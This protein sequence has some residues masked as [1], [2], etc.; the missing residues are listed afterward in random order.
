[1]PGVGYLTQNAAVGAISQVGSPP[2]ATHTAVKGRPS[3]LLVATLPW[4]VSAA[5][6]EQNRLLSSSR[7]H[8]K[9]S[10]SIWWSMERVLALLVIGHGATPELCFIGTEERRRKSCG[11]L[12][13]DERSTLDAKLPL[14][15]G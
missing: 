11:R 9:K 1:M 4:I 12:C 2:R 5:V 10:F 13:L 3:R 8:R 14:R 15:A 7:S 6:S